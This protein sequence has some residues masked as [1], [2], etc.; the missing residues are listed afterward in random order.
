MQYLLRF[1]RNAN[2]QITCIKRKKP[3]PPIQINKPTKIGNILKYNQFTYI[4][5]T[6]RQCFII[7]TGTLFIGMEC[8]VRDIIT[9][10]G[11]KLHGQSPSSCI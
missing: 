7:I 10:H 2:S 9:L 1:Q 5:I 11:L 3:T 6:I 4:T 8:K